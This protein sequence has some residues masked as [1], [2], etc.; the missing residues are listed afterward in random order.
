MK[1]AARP[2]TT[3]TTPLRSAAFRRFV[4]A[5]LISATGTAMAPLA[6]AYA[7]IGEGGGA[8]SLGLVLATNTVP[9]VVFLLAGGVLADRMSRSRIL[10]AGNV[11][12]AAAQGVLAVVVLSGAASTL[13]IAACGFLSGV[14]MAW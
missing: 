9:T 8:G 11:V 3:G 13:S 1:T 5:N 6:L 2:R 12:A 10:V 4:L 14:A 7:V